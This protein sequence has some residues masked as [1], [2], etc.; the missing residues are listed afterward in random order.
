MNKI[1]RAAFR[2]A[3]LIHEHIGGRCPAL[4]A[5]HRSESSWATIHRLN[6]QANQAASRGWHRAAQRLAE[7]MIDAMRRLAE[8]MEAAKRQIEAQT[9]PRIRPAVS[10]IYQDVLALQEEFEEVE[11]NVTEHTLTVTTDSIV[12]ED[13]DFGRFD[14]CLD[15][16][17][18]GDRQPYRVVARDPNPATSRSDVTHPHV[19]D[20]MLCEGE[21]R[22]AI[23][24]ALAQSRLYDFFMLVSQILHTYGQGSAYVELR[25]W[26]GI[27]CDDCGTTVSQDDSYCCQRCGNELCDDCRQSCAA[28]D[29]SHCTGCLTT[30]PECEMEFCRGCLEVCP[31]CRRH[32]CG[33]CVENGLCPTCQAEHSQDEKEEN[34]DE[35]SSDQ[36]AERPTETGCAA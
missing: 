17:R 31:G 18:L 20:E 21:G 27:R 19:Q 35:E 22:T 8:D 30:C 14:I 11:I 34:D 7:E 16:R 12:L 32:I 4:P 9:A 24:A 1:D 25:D 13:I 29:E 6:R 28:C 5:F 26:T 10:E 2:A 33:G 3:V 15:W 36:T 23:Q